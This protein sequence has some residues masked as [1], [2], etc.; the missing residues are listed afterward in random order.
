MTAILPINVADLLYQR[1]V[2]AAR[3]EFKGSWN[4]GPTASQVLRTISAF[5]NDLQNLNGGYVVLG[6]EEEG[7]AA[8]LPPKG[9]EADQI[10]SIQKRIRGHCRRLDPEYQPIQ[11]PEV[12]E[13]GHLLVVWAPASDIRPHAAPEAG[14]GRGRKYYVRLGAETV[15]ARGPHLTQL[16][17][18]SATVPFDDRPAREHTLDDLRAA[19]VR[20]FLR[21][22][23]SALLDERDDREVY[24]R[25][26][27]AMRLN[28]HE[29][30]RNVGLMFFSDDPDA[31]F[32]G[33][34]IEAAAF[35][36][37]GDVLEEGM[38]RGPLQ[39]QINDCLAWL[40]AQTARHVRKLPDR[41]ETDNWDDYPF[42]A[43]EEAIVNAIYHR[44]Y[45]AMPEPVKVYVYGD[46][47]EVTSY[48]GP[49]AGLEAKHFL[50]G[51]EFPTV[52]A[53]NRR[54]GELLKDLRMAEARGTGVIKI[55]RAMAANGSPPPEFR[56]DDERSY[57]TV[58]LPIHPEAAPRSADP[59]AVASGADALLLISL[60]AQSIRPVVERSLATLGLEDARVLVD[61]SVAG[62]VDP[63]AEAR[64]LREPIRRAVEDPE[65]GRLHLFY[66]GPL[67]VVPVLGALIASSAKP[68]VVYHYEDGRYRPAYTMDRRY[69]IEE[70]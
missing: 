67:A 59:V 27:I 57:F 29:V 21:E 15:E 37:G 23:G 52:A 46:R 4:D 60:G 12:F 19:L 17:R 63:G 38:F 13:G 68:L 8:K 24:R 48:P 26:R 51:A 25:L 44:S 28:D 47:I 61:D 1:R 56:F 33:A 49:V 41:P 45:E 10:E 20:E 40:R 66:R 5:A 22:I 36:N 7:G 11:S 30:P 62:H 3:I 53:R 64:R 42:A 34:R 2:E 65:V 32:R 9:L 58:V 6:V 14:D 43:L 18:Q 31:S 55:R 39:R 50:P 54:I 35:A 16:M 69:L 70:G